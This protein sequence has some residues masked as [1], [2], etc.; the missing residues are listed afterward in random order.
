MLGHILG[1]YLM[2][3]QEFKIIIII[4]YYKKVQD[5]IQNILLLEVVYKYM[6]IEEVQK[7]P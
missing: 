5:L 2:L 7:L 1:D 4:S 3:L 6:I